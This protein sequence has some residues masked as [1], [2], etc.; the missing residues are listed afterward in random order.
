MAIEVCHLTNQTEPEPNL[1]LQVTHGRVKRV[2]YVV[3][4]NRAKSPIVQAVFVHVRERWRGVAK[5][6]HEE[7]FHYSLEV[8]KAPVVHGKCLNRVNGPFTFVAEEAVHGKVV[9][10]GVDEEGAQ[11]LEKEEGAVRYLGAQVLEHDG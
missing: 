6:V 3:S 11:V 9:E 1:H 7:S 8:V 5:T 2:V 4:N 10:H